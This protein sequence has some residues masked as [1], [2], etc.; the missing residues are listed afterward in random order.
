MRK[1]ILVILLPFFIKAQKPAENKTIEVKDSLIEKNISAFEKSKQEAFKK[2][3]SYRQRVIKGESMN[4]LA[5][6]Y[7]EDPGSAKFGGR[8]NNVE[9][10][11]MVREFE[12]VAFSL[13]EGEISE[14]FETRFGYH[15]I[16]LISAHGEA[17]DL[18]HFLVK[19]K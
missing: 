14:V 4:D 8:I 19:V 3:E 16:Q 7:S 11:R 1:I 2:I 10:G 9:R 12:D 5:A 18:R 13:K 15:F 17:V 6:L